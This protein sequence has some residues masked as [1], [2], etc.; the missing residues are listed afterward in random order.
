MLDL[1]REIFG[2]QFFY[3]N[4]LKIIQ[5]NVRVICVNLRAI[6]SRGVSRMTQIKKGLVFLK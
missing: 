5:R 4:H 3:W 6:F 1:R 2:N